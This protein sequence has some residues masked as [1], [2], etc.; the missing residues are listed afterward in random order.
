MLRS[1]PLKPI[2]SYFKHRKMNT[3]K[4]ESAK[5]F[6][7]GTMTLSRQPSIGSMAIDWCFKMF[8]PIFWIF[9]VFNRITP[10]RVASKEHNL[11]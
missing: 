10:L 5:H 6:K 7:G 1:V 8:V 3:L 2:T 4:I 9:M 11:S